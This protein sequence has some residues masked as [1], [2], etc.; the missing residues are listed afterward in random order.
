MRVTI[1]DRCKKK[2]MSHEPIGVISLEE[3]GERDTLMKPNPW[4]DWDLCPS[5]VADI[6]QYVEAPLY[7]DE[8][9]S[10]RRSL[11]RDRPRATRSGSSRRQAWA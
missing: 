11:R 9:K 10:R 2:M 7:D 5:C 4:K 8:K 3:R 6:V 1:C